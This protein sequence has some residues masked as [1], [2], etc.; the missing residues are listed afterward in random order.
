MPVFKC[1]TGSQTMGV[2]QPASLKMSSDDDSSTFMKA[3]KQLMVVHVCV[4][5]ITKP[6]LHCSP[7]S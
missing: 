5:I 7:M 3:P 6:T 1:M 4:P 2:R